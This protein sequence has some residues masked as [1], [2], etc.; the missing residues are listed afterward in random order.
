[1]CV[2]KQHFNFKQRFFS[3]S[4]AMKKYEIDFKYESLP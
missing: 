4:I 1:M 2:H 3:Q